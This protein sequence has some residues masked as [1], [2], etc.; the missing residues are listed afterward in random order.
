MHIGLHCISKYE[1]IAA[2][3]ANMNA[4][5]LAFQSISAFH[6]SACT[7]V[8]MNLTNALGGINTKSNGE[9]NDIFLGLDE[10]W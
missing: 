10:F 7:D 8:Q 1:C 9:S 3:I 6:I 2:S 4:Y 5:R